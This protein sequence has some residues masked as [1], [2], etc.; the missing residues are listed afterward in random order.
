MLAMQ[1]MSHLA[2]ECD[3]RKAYSGETLP[4]VDRWFWVCTEEGCLETGS[5]KLSEEPVTSPETYWT[6]MR[7]LMPGCWIPASFRK[8]LG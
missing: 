8:R 5:D 2:P 7:R 1:R 4:I 3:H 6:A